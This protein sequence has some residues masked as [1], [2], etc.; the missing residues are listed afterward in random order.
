MEMRVYAREQAS[1]LVDRLAFQIHHAA[2]AS[3][4]DSVHDLRVA[5]RRFSQGLR[6]F[7][8]FLPKGEPKKIRRR[9]KS[10]MDVAAEVRNRDIALELLEQSGLPSDPELVK[11]LA[12][13]RRQVFAEL[14]AVIKNWNRRNYS[15]KW[16]ARL[17][18]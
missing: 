16:R 12:A 14:V 8:Q 11:T 17:G 7:A 2:K 10:L 5:I 1:T 18:L 13:E 6:V 9:V 3:D 4:A 15:Q